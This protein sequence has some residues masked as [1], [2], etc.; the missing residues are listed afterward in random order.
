[1]NKKAEQ[2][3]EPTPEPVAPLADRLETER[4]MLTTMQAQ[5]KDQ[6]LGVNNQLLLIDRLLNPVEDAPEDTPDPTPPEGSM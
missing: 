4:T 3:A 6:L 1:M 5:L 2:I